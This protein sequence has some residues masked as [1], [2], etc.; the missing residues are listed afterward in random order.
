LIRLSEKICGCFFGGVVRSFLTPTPDIPIDF[1]VSL[2]KNAPNPLGVLR[3]K[4]G[5]SDGRATHRSEMLY[6]F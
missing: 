6:C 4:V 5:T 2:L 3:S 1:R